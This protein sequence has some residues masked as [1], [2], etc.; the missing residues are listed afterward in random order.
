MCICFTVIHQ[1]TQ[2]TKQKKVTTVKPKYNRNN[3]EICKTK[4]K[5][6]GT[7]V[8]MLWAALWISLSHAE[9]CENFASNFDPGFSYSTF[10]NS[11]FYSSL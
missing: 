5:I 10:P 6:T 2:K 11:Q 3:N 7:E 1:T 4:D 9:I 8:Y